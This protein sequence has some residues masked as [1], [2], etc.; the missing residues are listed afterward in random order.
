M[1]HP[2]C[3]ERPRHLGKYRLARRIARRRRIDQDRRLSP[4]SADVVR[5]GGRRSRPR[6]LRVAAPAPLTT[7]GPRRP[8]RRLTAGEDVAH[9][10]A[11]E[12]DDREG[13]DEA[14]QERDGNDERVDDETGERTEQSVVTKREQEIADQDRCAVQPGHLFQFGESV[15]QRLLKSTGY[16]VQY[17]QDE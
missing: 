1:Y 3:V 6:R 8:P 4:Y 5:R 12:E 13:V 17:V 10:A 14:E 2:I 11:A 9:D 16:D 15:D 7:P